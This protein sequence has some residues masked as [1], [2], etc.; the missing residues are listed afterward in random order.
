MED[1]KS[2]NETFFFANYYK[3]ARRV[4]SPNILQIRDPTLFLMH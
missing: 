1:L 3:R 4:G 2:H